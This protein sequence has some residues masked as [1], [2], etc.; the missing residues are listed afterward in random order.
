ME[1]DNEPAPT[2]KRNTT[3]RKIPAVSVVVVVEVAED[4]SVN[5]TRVQTLVAQMLRNPR[6]Q[7]VRNT[8]G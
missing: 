7:P 6:S 1:Q 5:S 2:M 4:D 8:I 3:L